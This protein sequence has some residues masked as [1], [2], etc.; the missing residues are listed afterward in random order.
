MNNLFLKLLSL[1][2]IILFNLNNLNA[3]TINA[4]SGGVWEDPNNW[5][6]LCI[7]SAGDDV[8]IDGY[9][10]DVKNSTG[11]VSVNS[12]T[13]TNTGTSQTVLE[14][15]EAITMT[16][17]GDLTMTSTNNNKAISFQTKNTTTVNIGGNVNIERSA[18]NNVNS[19]LQFFMN[20]TS[21]VN[22]SGNF[23]FNY[24]NSGNS[25]SSNEIDLNGD[26]SLNVTQYVL[27]THGGGNNFHCNLDNDAQFIIGGTFDFTQT[28]GDNAKVTLGTNC[29]LQSTG[30]MTFTKSGGSLDLDLDSSGNSNYVTGGDLTLNSTV[31]G[32]IIDLGCAGNINATG[33]VILI[34]QAAGNIDMSLTLDGFISLGGSFTR[35]SGFGVL[36]MGNSSKIIYNGTGTQQITGNA[37]SGG[38]S[39]EFTNIEIDNSSG[40]RLTLTGEVL[41]TKHLTLTNGIVESSSSN[42]L[43][44]DGGSSDVGSATSFVDGPLQKKK[45]GAFTFPL[46]DN[47]VYA[48]LTI[49]NPGGSGDYTAQFF[50][51]SYSNTSSMVGE[52]HQ[53]S[54]IEYWNIEKTAGND[55]TATFSWSDAEQ[56]GINDLTTL[57]VARFDGSDWTSEGANNILGGIGAG[58]SGSITSNSL[59]SYGPFTFGSTNSSSNFLPIE[60]DYFRGIYLNEN[61]VV[62]LEWKTVSENNNDYFEIERSR[63][64]YDF[65]SI[66]TVSGYGF[67]TTPI[68][69]NYEDERPL[70]G[71]I[72]YRL[73]QVDFDG[74]FDYASI[75]TIQIGH[76]HL[77]QVQLYPNPTVDYIFL[78]MPQIEQDAP[79]NLRIVNIAG[80]ILSE[81]TIPFYAQT[82]QIDLT[83]FPSGFYFLEMSIGEEQNVVKFQK[84]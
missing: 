15:I 53:I 4:I 7:P 32:Q 51:S 76:Q 2:F 83:Q 44:I 62:Q 23:T 1:F 28:G 77:G 68:V 38:D 61:K 10:I 80:Q 84:E 5:D 26:C 42:K 35:T 78:K 33:N 60:L 81:Q 58:V 3:A 65:E 72:Y 27:L 63:N 49:T 12:I 75:I 41:M 57:R 30:N 34:A 14:L 17:A 21:M 48:P 46:G 56:S 19:K 11:N 55:V 40:N 74:N 70:T 67:S 47:D 45:G 66:G 59:T 79:L 37:G 18:D 6:C 64:G 73:K 24:Q 9:S 52:L 25:E 31:A 36:T 29:K 43:I 39:F 16:I 50:N 13:L 22:V 82:Q 69:Y 71:L 20:S 54:K 8:I